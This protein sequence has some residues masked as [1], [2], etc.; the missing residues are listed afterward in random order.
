MVSHTNFSKS[1]QE[2]LGSTKYVRHD[3]T[4]S[5]QASDC[6]FDPPDSLARTLTPIAHSAVSDE[7]SLTSADPPE[8]PKKALTVPTAMEESLL[9]L[10]DSDFEQFTQRVQDNG[11]VVS[12]PQP[13]QHAREVK[14][15]ING[16]EP[17]KAT[18]TDDAMTLLTE[19]SEAHLELQT[20]MSVVLR[21]LT[22]LDE[23]ALKIE[24]ATAELRASVSTLVDSNDGPTRPHHV[25]TIPDP[26]PLTT[27]LTGYAEC[28]D[29]PSA[30]RAFITALRWKF[31]HDAHLFT[32]E[33]HKIANIVSHTRAAV[34]ESL[35]DLVDSEGQFYRASAEAIFRF[36]ER[37][38]IGPG[39]SSHKVGSIRSSD[40]IEKTVQ[41]QPRGLHDSDSTRPSDII[42][43][44]AKERPRSSHGLD[45]TR[46]LDV[47]KKTVKERLCSLRGLGS[48]RALD[49]T[50]RNVEEWHCSSG[51][52]DSFRL[53][54]VFFLGFIPMGSAWLIL[55]VLP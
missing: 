22:A 47:I 42:E 39:W 33:Q 34:R 48:I 2:L 40:V 13:D 49:V 21:R 44:T 50:K 30:C 4:G 9:D 35:M 24:D 19:L 45:S 17:E 55:K 36:M 52:M 23:R 16:V 20:D 27:D 43:R 18:R 10:E 51:G 6:T 29:L 32:S 53:V 5:S 37:T 46:T 14:P 15:E 25:S 12:N 26:A 41:E 38:I 7:G 31:E 28:L 8:A 11:L 1:T 54:D 3:S